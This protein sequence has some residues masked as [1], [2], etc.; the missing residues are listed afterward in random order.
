MLS[1]S[2][3]PL[4]LMQGDEGGGRVLQQRWTSFL[5]AQLLCLRPDDGFPFNVLQDMFTLTPRPEDWPDTLFYGVFTSQWCA[6]RDLAGNRPGEGCMAGLTV[7]PKAPGAHSANFLGRSGGTTE[8]SAVCVF[9][10]KDVQSTFNGFYKEVN[11]ETQQWY[12]VTHPVPSPRPGAVS[13]A[14]CCRAAC[15]E[16]ASTPRAGLACFL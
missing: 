13:A 3:A 14:P 5:K 2:P 6:P 1:L 8:G 4:S 12:T 10:M 7:N 9:T 11:R 16:D 15:W